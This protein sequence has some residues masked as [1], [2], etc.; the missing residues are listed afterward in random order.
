MGCVCVPSVTR[1]AITNL[2]GIIKARWR[3]WQPGI[4]RLVVAMV[5]R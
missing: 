4:T 1:I 5:A 3:D 2:H